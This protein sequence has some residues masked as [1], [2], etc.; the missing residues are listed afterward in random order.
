MDNG[1]YK[2]LNG[3]WG[4]Q[5]MGPSP[6]GNGDMHETF[7]VNRNGDIFGGHTTVRI[8]GGQEIRMPWEPRNPR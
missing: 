7:G 8:P 6:L 1:A 3:G 2:P 4:I 5:P